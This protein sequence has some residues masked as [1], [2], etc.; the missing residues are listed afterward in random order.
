MDGQPTTIK[1]SPG[2][3]SGALPFPAEQATTGC[4]AP[5]TT[6]ETTRGPT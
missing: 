4:A 6:V 1:K 2:D 5:L 3:S